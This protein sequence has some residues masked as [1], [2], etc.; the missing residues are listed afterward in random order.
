MERA[1]WMW[2]VVGGVGG[3]MVFEMKAGRGV[4][5]KSK[6]HCFFFYDDLET[7]NA[8]VISTTFFSGSLLRIS[9]SLGR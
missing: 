8:H 9:V 7:R 1:R 3:C 5:G 2:R 6:T 4:C